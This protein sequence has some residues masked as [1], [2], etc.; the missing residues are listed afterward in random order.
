MTIEELIK[1]NQN[2]IKMIDDTIANCTFVSML[3]PKQK[4]RRNTQ[5]ACLEHAKECLISANMRFSIGNWDYAFETMKVA[6]FFVEL[7]KEY[8]RRV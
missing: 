2:L 1:N 4:D 5:I 7:A 8:G 6:N 3:D